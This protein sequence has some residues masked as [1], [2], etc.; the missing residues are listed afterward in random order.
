MSMVDE[1]LAFRVVRR[2]EH[3]GHDVPFDDVVAV[4]ESLA[5]DTVGSWWVTRTDG[6]PMYGEYSFYSSNG[7]HD[8]E[9]AENESEDNDEAVEYRLEL[10]V[11]IAHITRVYADGVH[12]S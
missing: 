5:E 1:A 3:V 8:W 2:L 6:E 7:P 11:P 9:A 4:L 12:R 10:L